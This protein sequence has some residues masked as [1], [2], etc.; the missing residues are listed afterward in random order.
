MIQRSLRKYQT[1]TKARY[2]TLRVCWAIIESDHSQLSKGSEIFQ[3][4]K[5]STQTRLIQKYFH[6]RFDIFHREHREYLIMC[7]NIYREWESS[8]KAQQIRASLFGEDF[9]APPLQFPGKPVL[10]LFTNREVLRKLVIRAGHS[11]KTTKF[12]TRTTIRPL[13]L[14]KE[15]T[16]VREVITI[17]FGPVIR[18][19]IYPT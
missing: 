13:E 15:E 12:G 18:Q 5:Y 8:N 11:R 17:A 4:V 19:L 9:T 7:S 6:Y 10:K 14:N 2:Y 3:T 1:I 16:L